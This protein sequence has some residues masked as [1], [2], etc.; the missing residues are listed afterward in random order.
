MKNMKQTGKMLSIALAGLL[1]TGSMVGCGGAT[2]DLDAFKNRPNEVVV[3]YASNAYGKEWIT[4]IAE[5]YMT[6][7]NTDT[8]INLKKTVTQTEELAKVE[9]GVAVGDLYLLDCHLEEKVFAYENIAD[10]YDSYPIGETDKKVSEK[11]IDSYKTYFNNAGAENFIIPYSSV[12]GGYNFAYNKTLLDSLLPD[13]YTLP[14]TTDEF[15]ELGN[16][17]KNDAYLLLASF[18]D[19]SDYSTYMMKAWFTQLMGYENYEQ[20]MQGRYWDETAEKYVF[21]EAKPTVYEANKVALEDFFDLIKS[22]YSIENG[23]LHDDWVAMD[24]MDVEAALAGFGF[25]QNAKPGVFLVNGSY[26]E[27]E[28]GWMLAEQEAADNKQEIRMMQMP[29]ASDIIKRTPSIETDAELRMVIDYVDKVLAGESATKPETVEDADIEII[30]EARSVCGAYMAGGMIIPKAAKNKAGAK[31]FIRYLA[32]DE[33]AIIAAQNTNGINL[34]P[35]GKQVT[36][37]EL[38]FTRTDFMSDC[39]RISGAASNVISSDSQEYKFA[40]VTKFGLSGNAFGGH[41]LKFCNGTNTL[42]GK[43]F[44]QESYDVFAG[45]WERMITEFKSQGGNT[46]N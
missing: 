25:G 27:Q 35:F 46:A 12:T 29:V 26:L 16:I 21:D 36:D 15:L 9:S 30:K 1:A 18:K 44:Y 43:A 28:M 45:K 39:M 11:L 41:I 6:D 38:G 10:V 2:G 20:F 34:L 22:I 7:H 37:E 40:Y 24:A 19:S 3:Y 33:A 8:Y 13:G 31:D 4:E 14:R 5:K 32:S 42:T 17:I 23:Y